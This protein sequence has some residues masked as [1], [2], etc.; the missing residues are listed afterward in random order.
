MIGED[1]VIRFSGISSTFIVSSQANCENIIHS[2]KVC[3]QN[4]VY[5][6]DRKPLEHP[7]LNT[8]C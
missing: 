7:F 8:D 2:V 4:V 6:S 3:C 1:K 5:S